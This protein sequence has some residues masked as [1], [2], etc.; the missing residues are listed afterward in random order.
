M[1]YKH[2]LVFALKKIRTLES[3]GSIDACL[4][5]LLRIAWGAMKMMPMM[6][7]ASVVTV[8]FGDAGHQSQNGWLWVPNK[9][10]FHSWFDMVTLK[11]RRWG[12]TL[13]EDVVGPFFLPSPGLLSLWLP[14]VL[15]LIEHCSN[16]S[17]TV[18]FPIIIIHS[19]HIRIASSHHHHCHSLWGILVDSPQ[20][21]FTPR[22]CHCLVQFRLHC[23]GVVGKQVRRPVHLKLQQDL[24]TFA[25]FVILSGFDTASAITAREADSSI[26]LTIDMKMMHITQTTA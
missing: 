5:L 19:P 25:Y 17:S 11:V 2:W 26:S 13:T 12:G 18:G 4:G 1:P 7:A 3:V 6:A 22:H 20:I 14:L 21:R 10:G 16:L 8:I 24:D 15:L 23:V 9:T